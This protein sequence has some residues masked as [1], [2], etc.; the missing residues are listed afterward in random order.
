M[1]STTEER[2]SERTPTAR[3]WQRYLEE[4]RF[5]TDETYELI[6]ALAWRRL[7][8]E[9]TRLAR[10]LLPR[11]DREHLFHSRLR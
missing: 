7:H 10:L 1:A 8:T 9:L 11:A 3:A 4:T 2:H 6:E 5:A